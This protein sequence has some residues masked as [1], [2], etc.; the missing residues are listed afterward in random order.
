MLQKF[1]NKIK[2]I[3]AGIT[4]ERKRADLSLLRLDYSMDSNDGDNRIYFYHGLDLK[5]EYKTREDSRD[6]EDRVR[7]G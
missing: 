5:D 3:V 1:T 4:K 6:N 7:T 2:S